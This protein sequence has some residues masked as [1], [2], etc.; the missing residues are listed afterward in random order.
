MHAPH[1]Y[2]RH[3]SNRNRKK[4]HR[5]IGFIIVDSRRVFDREDVKK[6]IKRKAIEVFGER[7]RETGLRLTRYKE[8]KGMV[9]CYHL[10]KD[11]VIELLGSIKKINGEN[12]RIETIGTSGTIKSLNRKYF[13]GMLKKED[14]PDYDW[15][16]KE[17]KLR[18]K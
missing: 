6:A 18:R 11:E 12:V 8:N 15:K 5:Y 2:L 10:Y 14:D 16:R 13:G 9:H 7:V 3:A 4:R 17:R 1:I